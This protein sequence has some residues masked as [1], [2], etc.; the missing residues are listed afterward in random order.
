MIHRVFCSIQPCNRVAE[1][2]FELVSTDGEVENF[3]VC[4]RHH[5]YVVDAVYNGANPYEIL[6]R[7]VLFVSD[8][9]KQHQFIIDNVAKD[10]NPYDIIYPE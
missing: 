7:P 3:P 2:E 6:S 5:E 1:G 4:D 9:A 10:E 8:V